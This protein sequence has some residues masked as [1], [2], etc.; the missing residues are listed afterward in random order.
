MASISLF[1]IW[2]LKYPLFDTVV[3]MK[4]E[5]R[6]KVR[7]WQPYKVMFCHATSCPADVTIMILDNELVFFFTKSFKD[8]IGPEK[9]TPHPH[10]PGY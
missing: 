10:I 8:K 7:S 6:Y 9:Q 1:N 2:C 4:S 3:H 5:I